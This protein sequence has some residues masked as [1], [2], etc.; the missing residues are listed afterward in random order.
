MPSDWYWSSFFTPVPI[1]IQRSVKGE[2]LYKDF[3][4][5]KK[6]VS[7]TKYLSSFCGFNNLAPQAGCHDIC[8]PRIDST[9]N[10]NWMLIPNEQ[11]LS[12]LAQ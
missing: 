11:F 12:F 7:N 3:H 4:K 5:P 2:D 9:L 8:S 1:N 6:S 10:G